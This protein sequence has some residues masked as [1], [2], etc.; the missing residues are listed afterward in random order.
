MQE[1]DS[2]LADLGQVKF[3]DKAHDGSQAPVNIGLVSAD[4]GRCR[5]RLFAISPVR[6]IRQWIR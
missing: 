6:H 5:G 2:F 3:F 4:L 1:L